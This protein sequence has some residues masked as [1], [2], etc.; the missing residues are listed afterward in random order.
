MVIPWAKAPGDR[1]G[2]LE[3]VASPG[4]SPGHVSYLDTRDRTQI[5]GDVYTT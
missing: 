5:A 4:H 1:A 2:S 3:V